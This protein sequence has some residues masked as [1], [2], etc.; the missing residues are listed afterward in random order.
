MELTDTQSPTLAAAS[1]VELLV[2]APLTLAL[3]TVKRCDQ[4]TRLRDTI[5]CGQEMRSR[6]AVKRCGQ[7][8]RWS[9]DAVKRCG[10]EMQ[11]RDA[12]K[13]CGQAVRSSFTYQPR[14]CPY[15]T[16]TPPSAKQDN[17][18]SA[19]QRKRMSRE[20]IATP[21]V[22]SLF[23]FLPEE[24]PYLIRLCSGPIN[25]QEN[26]IR[27]HFLFSDTS[28][29]TRE[30]VSVQ[31]CGRSVQR[32]KLLRSRNMVMKALTYTGKPSLP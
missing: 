20:N 6:D 4:E 7:K 11:S 23:G 13:R 9:R 3:A 25:V 18:P 27:L 2:F 21:L 26:S 10:H 19:M 1:F 28:R 17:R 22:R 5:R 15:P 31:Q 16:Y 14:V 29:R 8:M 30:I 32:R 24:R 12:V